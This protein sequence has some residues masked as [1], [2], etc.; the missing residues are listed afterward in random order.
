M[1]YYIYMCVCVYIYIYIYIP[2]VDIY[3]CLCY[4]YI[5]LIYLEGE[6]LPKINR[7]YY[8]SDFIVSQ[9]RKNMFVFF[10]IKHHKPVWLQ[11]GISQNTF[12][13]QFFCTLQSRKLG[14]FHFFLS[15][16]MQA[17]LVWLYPES[18]YLKIPGLG[19]C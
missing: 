9:T 11:I 7:H 18:S 10:F 17:N 19:I 1:I 2:K 4:V 16:H 3:D 14:L 6:V 15:K 13:F 12:K 8:S 5:F